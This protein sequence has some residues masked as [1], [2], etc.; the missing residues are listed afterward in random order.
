MI[1]TFLRWFIVSVV[2]AVGVPLVAVTT[3]V[4]SL[5]F[6]PLPATLPN[7]KP[8]FISRPSVVLDANGNQ[9]A[10]FSEFDQS[11]PVQQSD[12]PVVL[13]QALI[14]SEDRNCLLYTSPSPRDRQKSRMPSSA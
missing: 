4:G 11:V 10:T 3:I 12:I 8:L 1:R 14:A 7:P 5:I 13:K 9:I 2:S 6:L